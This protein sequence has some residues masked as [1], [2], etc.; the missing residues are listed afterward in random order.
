MTESS[1]G[2][3]SRSGHEK[4]ASG[5]VVYLIEELGDA[6]LRTAQLKK[7]VQE[8]VD[9]IDKA[10]NRDQLFE[11]AGHLIHGIP[12]MLFKLD[13]ALDASAMAAARLDYEEI[14]QN[15]KPEKA[16]ELE[17][18]LQDIRLP[19][20]KRRSTDKEA[21]VG[22]KIL[23]ELIASYE[24]G[25]HSGGRFGSDNVDIRG[26]ISEG[27][28]VLNEVEAFAKKNA[29]K[30]EPKP[31]LNKLANACYN[32]A[33]M[34]GMTA[35]L[36]KDP[37]PF[38]GPEPLKPINP[39]K[40]L[41][42]FARDESTTM[43]TKQ[44]GS[45][46]FR[47]MGNAFNQGLESPNPRRDKLPKAIRDIENALDQIEGNLGKQAVVE[48][49]LSYVGDQV[50]DLARAVGEAC[51]GPRQASYHPQERHTIMKN[52][53]EAAAE[54]LKMAEIADATGKV[55]MARLVSL[56]A[57]LEGNQ[58]QAGDISKKASR[59]FQ[60]AAT[61]LSTQ[62]NPSRTQLA[63][64]LR[65]V[66]ADSMQMDAATMQSAIFQQA[67]SREDVMKGFQKANPSM[68]DEDAEKAA[69]QWEK[70]KNVV[71]DKH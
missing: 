60:Q 15:L 16:E 39:P 33:S 63:S 7:Y 31:L 64:V 34:M 25:V 40:F 14:K 19:Y 22:E 32:L 30:A 62:K 9:L 17:G 49:I 68:S 69:D 67:N 36:N 45:A 12:D 46:T 10:E 51:A 26:V 70:N 71:K 13:K 43:A 18:V 53:K 1:G 65:K 54:L 58:R 29:P 42:L 59:F 35:A 28:S 3:L 57:H 5:V 20:L 55:P 23:R 66:L 11:V 47:E 38:N 44:A 27:T 4:N 6:R 41:G 37:P 61:T 2:C 52:T 56:I 50:V 24:G 48:N 21:Q 8:A